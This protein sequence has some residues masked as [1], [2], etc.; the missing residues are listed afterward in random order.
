MNITSKD[1]KNNGFIPMKFTCDGADISPEIE[2]YNIPFNTKS[3]VMIMHDHDSPSGDFVHWLIWNIDPLCKVIN[4][5]MTPIGALEGTNDFFELGWKGPCPPEGTHRYEF[6]LF[7]LN[8]LLDLPQTAGK[9][10]LRDL[11]DEHIIEKTNIT[12]LY[13]AK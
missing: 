11:M 3:L 13:K 6:H 7:A 12:G 2:I 1:F 9:F 5:N 10:D 8:T 4:E